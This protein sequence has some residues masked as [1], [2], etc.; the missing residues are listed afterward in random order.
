LCDAAHKRDIK[1]DLYFSHSDWYDADFR[2]YGY[3]PLQIP[4][5]EQ[6]CKSQAPGEVET[7]Y[8]RT[9]G[10]QKA[11]LTIV[12]DPSHEEEQRMIRRHREQLKEL[13]T[14][15]GKIDMICLDIWL[16]PRVWPQLRETLIELRKLQPDVMFRARGI[17]NY[18]DYYTPERFIPRRLL[19]ATS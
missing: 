17:G 13:L 1:I 12:P 2:P 5:S 19:N 10:R 4:S 6:W 18:G 7:E 3:H 15:Y 11:Y 8:Q 16:G 9:K 14:N